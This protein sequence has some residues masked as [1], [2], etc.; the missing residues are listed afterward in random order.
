MRTEAPGGHLLRH[1]RRRS[2][3]SQ[4]QV[5][6]R[7]GLSAGYVAMLEQ[8]ERRNPTEAVLRKMADALSLCSDDRQELFRLFLGRPVD[9]EQTVSRP[10]RVTPAERIVSSLM[11]LSADP[12]QAAEELGRL[13]EDLVALIA[14][15]G[16]SEDTRAAVRSAR[17]LGMGYF[18][19][20]FRRRRTGGPAQD[21]RKKTRDH[22]FELAAEIRK[23]LEVFIDAKIPASKRV[24]LARDL[25]SF[26]R[27]NLTKQK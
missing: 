9:Q 19:P 6:A 11:S 15:R 3:L 1:L 21:R 13:V 16:E 14:A 2:G 24:S 12:G 22:E 5:A 4:A 25:V 17:L 27:W 23:L 20:D 26:A 10:S 18:C 8:G 7:A